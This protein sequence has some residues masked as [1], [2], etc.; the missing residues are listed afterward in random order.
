MKPTAASPRPTHPAASSRV[1]APCSTHPRRSTAAYASAVAAWKACVRPGSGLSSTRVSAEPGGKTARYTANGTSGSSGSVMPSRWTNQTLSRPSPT[2]PTCHTPRTARS[3]ISDGTIEECF[4]SRRN[5]PE[6]PGVT[7]RGGANATATVWLPTASCSPR[8]RTMRATRAT[9]VRI[10]SRAGQSMPPAYG[11]PQPGSL[12][13][14]RI[15]VATGCEGDGDAAGVETVHCDVTIWV[16][17]R[18]Q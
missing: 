2:T 15:R 7:A 14:T 9:T 4:T 17:P 1:D 16:T 12:P 3:R 11:S 10:A 18:K 13:A 5:A 8:T 6:R